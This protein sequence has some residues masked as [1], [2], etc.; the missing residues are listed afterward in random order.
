M[1]SYTFT[2]DEN[3]PA[4]VSIGNNSTPVWIQQNW[5]D[6]EYAQYVRK[7]GCGHCCTAMAL[8]LN[9]IKINPHEEFEHCRKMWGEPKMYEPVNEDNFLSVKGI[10]KVLTSFG[11]KAKCHGVPK[12]EGINCAKHIEACLKEGKLVILASEPSERLPHNPFSS[13]LHYVMAVC[14]DDNGKILIANSTNRCDAVNGIQY[15]DCETIAKVLYD[16]SEPKDFTWG[17]YD[18]IGTCGYVVVG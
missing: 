4:I 13:G 9:G 3:A 18:F 2:G 12:G 7:N 8:N 11:V 10:E 14:A 6:G 15:T 1:V 16:G 5:Q 17:R